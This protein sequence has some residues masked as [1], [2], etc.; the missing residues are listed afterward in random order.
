LARWFFGSGDG[1]LDLASSQVATVAAGR[2]R[3]IAAE[4]VGPGARVSAGRP[5]DAD[6]FHDRDELRGIAA[7]ERDEDPNARLLPRAKPHDDKAIA[8]VQLDTIAR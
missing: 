6:A 4:V 8:V 1:V 7:W 2:V 5:A 3:L